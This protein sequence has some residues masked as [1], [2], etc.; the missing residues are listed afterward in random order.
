MAAAGLEAVGGLRGGPP[1]PQAAPGTVEQLVLELTDPAT[2]ENALLEL[3][4]K[5]EAFPELAPYLWH[6]FGTVSALLQVRFQ[7]PRPPAPPRPA[8]PPV[9]GLPVGRGTSEAKPRTCGT[10]WRSPSG[11]KPL[12]ACCRFCHPTGFRRADGRP[13]PRRRSRRSTRT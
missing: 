6:S 3:S 5:R 12:A 1:A 4:K 7:P 11:G 10:R 2:R 9:P 13:P 8:P